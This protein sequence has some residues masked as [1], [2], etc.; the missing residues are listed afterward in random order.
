MSA[1]FPVKLVSLGHVISV[2]YVTSDC[3]QCS[4][5]GQTSG[6][7]LP[8]VYEMCVCVC[9][10]NTQRE[11]ENI[12]PL[13]M[14]VWITSTEGKSLNWFKVTC[15]TLSSPFPVFPFNLPQDPHAQD[16]PR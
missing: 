12:P 16:Y 6:V 10:K 11:K 9:A 15:S 14:Q 4:T 5:T 13:L 7:Y 8:A 2:S 1:W 3:P